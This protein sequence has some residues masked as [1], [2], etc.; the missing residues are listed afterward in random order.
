MYL[1]SV[2]ARRKLMFDYQTHAASHGYTG[3]DE[4][5]LSSVVD[6]R[7]RLE[8]TNINVFIDHSIYSQAIQLSRWDASGREVFSQNP[9]PRVADSQRQLEHQPFFHSEFVQQANIAGSPSILK[10]MSED[11]ELW[12]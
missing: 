6:L 11:K 3:Q 8:K 12:D 7:V 2:L 5:G 4:S 10:C 9:F 1:G